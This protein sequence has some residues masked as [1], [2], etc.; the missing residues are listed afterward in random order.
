[1]EPSRRTAVTR[2]VPQGVPGEPP[3]ALRGVPAPTPLPTADPGR[4]EVMRRAEALGI[5]WDRILLEEIQAEQAL[6]RYA[7]DI[8]AMSLETQLA[9]LPVSFLTSWRVRDEIQSLSCAARGARV[10]SAV[11]RLR[12]VFRRCVGLPERGRAAD[13]G[14]LELAYERVLLLQRVGRAA[15][16]S[17]GTTAERMAFVCAA[18]RC[19][20]DDAAWALCREDAPRAGHR[21]DAA[22]QKVRD[23]GF[24]VPRAATEARAFAELRRIVRASSKR[25]RRRAPTPRHARNAVSRPARVGLP[26]DGILK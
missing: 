16:R 19:G 13:T 10:P 5:P 7:P 21:L 3:G 17:R 14:H 24:Q 1:M 25:P 9:V 23:E 20:Y 4:L 18:V 2:Q 11:S 22:M 8:D 12:A 26:T 15:R 6:R